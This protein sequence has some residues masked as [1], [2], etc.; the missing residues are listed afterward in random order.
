MALVLPRL[1]VLRAELFPMRWALLVAR[2]LRRPSAPASI[3]RPVRLAASVWRRPRV[4]RLLWRQAT[5]MVLGQL[6]Q[7]EQRQQLQLAPRPELVQPQRLEFCLRPG[8][9]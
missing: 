5:P 4:P 1:K 7:P 2:V 6:L 3:V 8:L 9:D